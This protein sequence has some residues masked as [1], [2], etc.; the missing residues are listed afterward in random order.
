MDLGSTTFREIRGSGVTT[1]IDR[2]ITARAR[3]RIRKDR[4]RATILASR[5]HRSDVNVEVPF[6]AVISTAFVIYRGGEAREIRQVERRT[7][8]FVVHGRLVEWV[9]KKGEKRGC[10]AWESAL[11]N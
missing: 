4:R 9:V 8:D 7:L 1:G 6:C 3:R 11:Y 5:R 10:V 2:I